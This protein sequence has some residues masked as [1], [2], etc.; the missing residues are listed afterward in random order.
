M[1]VLIGNLSDFERWLD[2]ICVVNLRNCTIAAVCGAVL[3][4]SLSNDHHSNRTDLLYRLVPLPPSRYHSPRHCHP[5]TATQPRPDCAQSP[6]LPQ[7]G[8]YCHYHSETTTIRTALVRRIDWS[9]CHPAT[10]TS[11]ATNLP[12]KDILGLEIP[13]HGLLR[14]Q[15]PAGKKCKNRPKYV[16]NR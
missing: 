8:Q 9:H 11:R 14:V 5:V 16:K 1:G 6:K 7:L 12:Q 2:A 3:P 13:V 10:A 4:L 15:I